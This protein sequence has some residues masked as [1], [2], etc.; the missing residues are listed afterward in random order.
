VA[1]PDQGKY[2][3]RPKDDIEIS[4]YK[5]P[6]LTKHLVVWPDGK[7]PYPLIGEVQAAGKTVKQLRAY[8]FDP[9]SKM[10]IAA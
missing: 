7:I 8:L 4:F 3:L 1:T 6:N 2:L 9:L 10:K 5:E